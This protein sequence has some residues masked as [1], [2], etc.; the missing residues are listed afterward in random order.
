MIRALLCRAALVLPALLAGC[1]VTDTDPAAG[2]IK[3]RTDARLELA[4]AYFV[5]GKYDIALQEIDSALQLSPKRPEALG[6]RGLAL[7]RL[8]E[9]ERALQSLQEALRVA[10]DDPG[11]MNNLGWVLCESGKPAQAMPYFD[12]ALANRRYASPANAA[13]NAGRCSLALGD[14]E[15]AT[16]YF[17]RALQ[18]EPGLS[19]AHAGLARVAY[20][21]GDLRAARERLL[22]VIANAQASADDY[23]LAVRV[24][25]KLGDREAER[26]LALQWQRR[27]PDSPLLQAYLR[28]E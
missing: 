8:G 4:N 5:E 14:R 21:R 12:R 22:P 6:L 24:E 23:A 1:A 19:A 3:Q 17:Q 25:Q 20:E 9:N 10:P 26:S 13:M 16:V 18:A 2:D 11:L 15:R 7:M 28:G 27:F